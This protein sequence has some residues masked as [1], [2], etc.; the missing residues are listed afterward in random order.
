[1]PFHARIMERDRIILI[2]GLGPARTE[3]WLE[4]ADRPDLPDHEQGFGLLVDLRR[5]QTLP[6]ASQA[7]ETGR[8]LAG[9]A[10]SHFAAVALIARPGAQFGLA[11]S[12]DLLTQLEGLP[13]GTFH[14][15]RSA[16]DWLTAVLRERR[17]PTG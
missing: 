12:V 8:R 1:M 10:A 9:I 5:R 2:R 15:L 6:T 11:R 16:C 3:D 14:E 4:L 13:A 17:P 7:R